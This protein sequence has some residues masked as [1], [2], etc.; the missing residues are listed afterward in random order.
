MAK[1][2]WISYLLEQVRQLP[3]ASSKEQVQFRLNTITSEALRQEEVI[4]PTASAF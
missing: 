3:I 4:P 1:N 2:Q